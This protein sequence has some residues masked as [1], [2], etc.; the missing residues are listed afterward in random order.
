MILA[1]RAQAVPPAT[2]PTFT[3]P[4]AIT[5]PFMPF[6]PGGV[7]VF[8]GQSDGTPTTVVDIYLHD[9]RT[10]QLNG[11]AVSTRVLRE[12][13]F[14]D[15][16]LSEISHNYFAQAD[17]GAV[18][19]FG[20]VVD[21]YE[22]NVVVEHGG[23]WLVGGPTASTDPAETANASVPGVFMVGNPEVGDAFKPEDLFP[24]VDETVTVQ[25]L[26]RSLKLP[27]FGKLEDVLQVM[28][29]SQLPDSTPETKWYARGVGV[30][31]ARARGESLAVVATT[32]ALP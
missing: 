7:K 14:E 4:L 1:G 30:V 13:E 26:R 22:Q 2:P 21:I 32:F 12:T 24:V 9:T 5:N 23:S 3:N 18:Y 17:D 19:Y 27:I 10:F 31:K 20:E 16:Q 6:A 28:E 8:K 25:G 15:G 29:T 11:V